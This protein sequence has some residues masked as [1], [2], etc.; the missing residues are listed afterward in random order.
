MCLSWRSGNWHGV[1][2]S[3]L[4]QERPV[5]ETL[6]LQAGPMEETVAKHDIL[7]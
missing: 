2:P 6:A 3:H 7:L 5:G 4:V 1:R